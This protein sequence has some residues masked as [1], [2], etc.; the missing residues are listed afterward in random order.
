ML[1]SE[2]ENVP[3]PEGYAQVYL[4]DWIYRGVDATVCGLKFSAAF[5]TEAVIKYQINA[6]GKDR[7][8]VD[9]VIFKHIEP[10]GFSIEPSFCRGLRPGP[11]WIRKKLDSQ[12]RQ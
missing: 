7:L 4:A 2:H 5:P 8:L 6:P 9:F 3:G 11:P 10:Q 12:L 1:R